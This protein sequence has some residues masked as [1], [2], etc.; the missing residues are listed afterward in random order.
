MNRAKQRME[1]N[2]AIERLVLPDEPY[3]KADTETII[4]FMKEA[5]LAEQTQ[6]EKHKIEKG[7]STTAT[8][9]TTEFGNVTASSRQ[10]E[11]EETNIGTEPERAGNYKLLKYPLSP[12]KYCIRIWYFQQ[13][14]T[15]LLNGANP[16]IAF[17]LIYDQE[18][19]TISFG[20]VVSSAK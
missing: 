13:D 11:H 7:G 12:T 5:P 19:N 15:A 10:Y 4:E 14:V 9:H 18:E 3:D 2:A 8:G 20:P 6:W 16:H 17:C 1:A